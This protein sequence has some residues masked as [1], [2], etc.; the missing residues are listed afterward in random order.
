MQGVNLADSRNNS[1][2]QTE[3]IYGIHP[4]L[5][6]L[7]AKRRKL[8]TLYTTKPEPKAWDQI[9]PL[10]T[11]T[12]VVRYVTR[13]ALTN[14]AQTTDHQGFVGFAGPYQFRKKPFESAKQ[15]FILMLD[16]I[17]DPRNLGAILRTAF[18]TGVEGV[19]ITKKNSAPL[20][21]VVLKASAG[22]A[23]YLEIVEA[24]SA[25]AA[26][27]ELIKAGYALYLATVDQSKP[28]QEIEYQLPLCIVIGSEGAGIS[29]EISSMGLHVS[30]P[31]RRSDISYN[32]SVAAGILLFL[33]GTQHKKI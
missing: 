32:A 17:Q 13:Q 19:I 25:K 11:S 23:E 28:A 24:P 7:K 18:C 22:L 29:P 21:A 14:T 12:T 20:N 16:G 33:I 6:L 1:K 26:A 30:L 8:L 2:I 3:L 15:S 5:E 4:I 31:Q 27:Q 10:L 9:R